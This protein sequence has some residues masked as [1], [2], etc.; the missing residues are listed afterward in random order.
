M[1]AIEALRPIE[2]RTAGID[3][4]VGPSDVKFKASGLAGEV[5]KKHLGTDVAGRGPAMEGERIGSRG[6]TNGG[7]AI[8]SNHKVGNTVICNRSYKTL[9]VENGGEHMVS[10]VN[11][12]TLVR[13]MDDAGQKVDWKPNMLTAHKGGARLIGAR[14]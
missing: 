3:E 9:G 6:R 10:R 12:Y 14:E 1:A 13:L 8:R 7:R 11:D 4:I 5:R 2:I